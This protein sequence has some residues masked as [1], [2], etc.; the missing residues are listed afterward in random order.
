LHHLWRSGKGRLSYQ[1]LHEFYVTVTDKLVPGMERAAARQDVR[2]LMVWDPIPLDKVV[3]EGAWAVQDSHRLSWWD[4]LIVAAAQV[5]GC[6]TLLTEDL[7]DGMD[8][9][10]VRVVNPFQH[11]PRG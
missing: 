10:G 11:D 4:A 2:D 9:D 8:L 6:N 1:V 3:L 7:Q 5:G